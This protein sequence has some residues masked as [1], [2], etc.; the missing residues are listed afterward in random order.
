M[1]AATRYN[2]GTRAIAAVTQEAEPP[3]DAAQWLQQGLQSKE[4]IREELAALKQRAAQLE[5]VL[6]LLEGLPQPGATQTYTQVEGSTLEWMRAV[7]T[8]HPGLTAGE[9]RAKLAERGREL[10]PDRCH[11]YLYRLSRKGLVRAEGVPGHHRY[12]TVNIAPSGSMASGHP[13]QQKP[14]TP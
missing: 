7:L 9:L 2:S 13:P 6:G 4:R 10:T 5:T 3:L 14:A 12:Y 8:T 11:T 1:S